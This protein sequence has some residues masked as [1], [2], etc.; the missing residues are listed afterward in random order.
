MFEQFQH[1]N[2]CNEKRMGMQEM[3]VGNFIKNIAR[4]TPRIQNIESVTCDIF[5]SQNHFKLI[6]LFTFLSYP[7]LNFHFLEFP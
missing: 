6:S 1:W 4:G 7:F 3:P 5:F 2:Q